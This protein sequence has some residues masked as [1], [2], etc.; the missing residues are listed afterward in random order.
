MSL[1]RLLG[2][3]A[4]VADPTALA[5]YYAELGLGGDASSGYTGSNGGAVVAVDEAPF[6]RLIAVDIGCH[7]D[8]DLDAVKQRLE[9]QGASPRRESNSVSVLDAASR[10]SITVRVA[11]PEAR[12]GPVDL[13]A[14]NAPDAVVRINE[15]A[16]GVF[17]A[18]RPPRRLGHLVI[19]TPDL[20]ATRD[21]LVDG[22]GCKVSDEADGIIHFLRCSIDHHNIGLV[23]SPVPLLQ[24]YSWEC[25]DLDHVGYA[26]TALYRSDPNR[27]AWGIGRH[28]AG[29]NFYWYLRDPAGSFLELYSDLD[30]ITDDAA[31]EQRGGAPL[32]LEHTI[33][34]W[35]PNLPTE[36]IVPDDLAELTAGWAT[37]A[38]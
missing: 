31:W 36:F 2:F 15:R 38:S 24:H 10:V 1:H 6:R 22:I 33:N 25:D 3:R 27:H 35:G 8:R 7:D 32:S 19:G 20:R 23:H 4:A 16:P 26:A 5:A 21:L 12:V 30:R 28:F 11:E 17:G 9:A 13:V 29:S 37:L 14:A 18:P 34:A